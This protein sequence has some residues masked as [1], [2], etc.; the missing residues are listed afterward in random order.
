MTPRI[1]DGDR[2]RAL[3]ELDSTLLVEA[4][5]GTGK[6]SLLAGRVAM[7]LAGGAAPRSIAAITFTE[8]AAGELHARAQGPVLFGVDW[9]TSISIQD[10]AIQLTLGDVP[11]VVAIKSWHTHRK[12]TYAPDFCQK[13]S[14]IRAIT[15]TYHGYRIRI[16]HRMACQRVIGRE[17]ILQ[18]MFAGNSLKLRSC[19]GVPAQI[20]RETNA[21]QG[22]DLPRANKIA[23][24]TTAPAMNEQNTRDYGCRCKQGP[25]ELLLTDLNLN[26]FFLCI[27]QCS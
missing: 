10:S 1:D 12:P 21:A 18:V 2:R 4:A 16:Y 6:T 15:A 19:S 13:R 8:L 24:Q 3:T 9:S 22:R 23:L 26:C 25:S 14:Q 17:E 5:A 27:H 11:L 7:L 20:K